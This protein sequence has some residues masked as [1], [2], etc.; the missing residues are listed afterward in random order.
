MY[1][2]EGDEVLPNMEFPNPGVLGAPNAGAAPGVP[3]ADAPG[4]APNAEPPAAGEPNA[5]GDAVGAGDPK[6]EG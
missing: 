1:V 6:V 2:A 5:E 3:N 4:E